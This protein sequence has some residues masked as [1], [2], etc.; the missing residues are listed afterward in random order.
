MFDERYIRAGWEDTDFF[1]QMSQKY[2]GKFA[3]ANTIRVTHLNEEKNCGGLQNRHNEELFFSKWAPEQCEM[4]R[5]TGNQ[6]SRSERKIEPN[7]TV[8]PDLNALYRAVLLNPT[9][10]GVFQPFIHES[11]RSR[12][13][14][15]LEDFVSQDFCRPIR[16]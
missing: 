2:G 12:R 5:S 10:M 11:Y 1:L 6:T 16:A 4:L 3:I 9:D 15:L 13:F 14:E 7:D 8:E